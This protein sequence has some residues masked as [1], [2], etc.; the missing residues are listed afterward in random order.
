MCFYQKCKVNF[1]KP[2]KLLFKKSILL[3]SD[4][5]LQL[6][7]TSLAIIIQKENLVKVSSDTQHGCVGKQNNV[8]D[9][10]NLLFTLF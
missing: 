8:T 7:V 9:L 3:E 10:F 1:L 5:P 6:H 2:D 4:N